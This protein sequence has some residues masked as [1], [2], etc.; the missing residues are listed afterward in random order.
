MEKGG[1]GSMLY[2]IYLKLR[3]RKNPK[4]KR[5]EVGSRD[6]GGRLRWV[7]NEGKK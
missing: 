3:G 5:R 4:E 1:R 2:A 7:D 6:I